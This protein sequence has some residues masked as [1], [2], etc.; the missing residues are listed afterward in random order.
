MYISKT[1]KAEGQTNKKLRN[2]IQ[3]VIQNIETAG[4]ISKMLV[5]R[6]N[7]FE[8]QTKSQKVSQK[9]QKVDQ[10]IEK[11]GH[12]SCYSSYFL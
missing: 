4:K 11:V 10:Q 1:Y 6:S 7:K 3:K 5:N 12:M 2:N 8:K 9:S